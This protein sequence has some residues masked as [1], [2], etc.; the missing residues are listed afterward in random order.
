MQLALDGYSLYITGAAG[1]G[2]THLFTR[3]QTI[4]K[5]VVD[6]SGIFAPDSQLMSPAKSLE[7]LQV[8]N[9][10]P[11]WLVASYLL[12]QLLLHPLY[13]SSYY[14]PVILSTF[15]K[16][17][18]EQKC[19]FCLATTVDP[20]RHLDTHAETPVLTLFIFNK[21]YS[22]EEDAEGYKCPLCLFSGLPFSLYTHLQLHFP[23]QLPAEG[24]STSSS[25]IEEMPP[26]KKRKLSLLEASD[27]RSSP[28]VTQPQYPAPSAPLHLNPFSRRAR[29][30]STPSIHTRAINTLSVQEPGTPCP[31]PGMQTP[32]SSLNANHHRRKDDLPPVVASLRTGL[33]DT[34]QSQTPVV[35]SFLN[36]HKGM[37]MLHTLLGRNSLH[38]HTSLLTCDLGKWVGDPD[39]QHFRTAFRQENNPG[40]CLSCGCPKIDGI[41]HQ[42][43]WDGSA[44]NCKDE[45]MQ[46]W[47]I[48]LAFYIWNFVEL[49]E[50]T[51]AMLE[52]PTDAFGRGMAGRTLFSR[53]LGQKN[54]RD[55]SWVASNLLDLLFVVAKN[56]ASLFGQFELKQE[57]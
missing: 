27:T 46:D 38:P 21:L 7:G 37:C 25:D 12:P 49:R 56:A 55:L 20:A 4:E 50:K 11:F 29:N 15:L 57:V 28:L 35:S 17:R 9:F 52:I 51:F 26:P 33:I 19:P 16:M 39:Y 18:S 13:I 3:G 1:T 10:D 6:F 53:W 30:E 32:P 41:L 22:L 47:I 54:G 2:K 31:N 23:S 45:D 43:Q 48:A 14:A 40:R 8:V 44:R 5:L 42:G 24:S 36:R 34:L